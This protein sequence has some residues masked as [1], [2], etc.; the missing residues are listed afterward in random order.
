MAERGHSPS[1]SRR[2]RRENCAHRPPNPA[3]LRSPPHNPQPAFGGDDLPSSPTGAGAANKPEIAAL[4]NRQTA[5]G[6]DTPTTMIT[7]YLQASA[8]RAYQFSSI[9]PLVYKR[10]LAN[11]DGREIPTVLVPAGYPGLKRRLRPP[12]LTIL[13]AE[14]PGNA[15]SPRGTAP[16]TCAP[17]GFTPSRLAASG[18]PQPCPPRASRVVF[19]APGG[20]PGHR[21][22]RGDR[23][24]G[25]R[26]PRR[27][28][29]APRR[30]AL[31][32]S[33]ILHS[34]TPSEPRR[35]CAP[36]SLPGWKSSLTVR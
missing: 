20:V 1:P 5:T 14:R 6:P 16:K 8:T 31:L 2:H 18:P 9:A 7:F 15:G 34:S 35:A 36:R 25:R 10:A 4:L 24:D 26:P 3:R 29:S 27:E 28:R 22:N 23:D 32:R 17:P 12:S 13:R 11:G 21:V 30:K 33:E 19:P